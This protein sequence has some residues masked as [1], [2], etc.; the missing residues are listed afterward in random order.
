MPVGKDEDGDI[1]VKQEPPSEP[2]YLSSRRRTRPAAKSAGSATSWLQ[3]ESNASHL[4]SATSPSGPRLLPGFP[5]S[6]A[7][8][9]AGVTPSSR[10]RCPPGLPTCT[11]CHAAEQQGQALPRRFLHD[12]P[13]QEQRPLPHLRA[14]GGKSGQWEAG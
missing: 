14:A 7:C 9:A 10:P 6:T 11:E 2:S 4:P 12:M 3:A 1:V 5:I 13:H 8:H